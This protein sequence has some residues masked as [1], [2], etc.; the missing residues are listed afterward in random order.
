MAE[1]TTEWPEEVKSNMNIDAWEEALRL[2]MS[3]CTRVPATGA[4][5]PSQKPCV[6]NTRTRSGHFRRVPGYLR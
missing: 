5:T 2:K 4:G 6:G 1:I 3:L